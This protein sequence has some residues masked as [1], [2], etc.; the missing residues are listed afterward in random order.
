MIVYVWTLAAAIGAAIAAWGTW[1]AWRDLRA[2]GPSANGRRILAVGWVRREAIRFIIQAI[3]AV[4]GFLALPA[5]DSVGP[6]SPLAYL[7]T[8]TTIA[9]AVNTLLDAKERFALRDIIS[10]RHD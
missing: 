8:A 2:L 6:V 5:A 4:I 1:D 3:W 10:D 9:V 7:L